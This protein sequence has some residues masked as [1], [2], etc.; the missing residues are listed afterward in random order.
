MR[1]LEI[2]QEAWLWSGI[3]EGNEEDGGFVYLRGFI[4]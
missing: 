4:F 2:N 3:R 1:M